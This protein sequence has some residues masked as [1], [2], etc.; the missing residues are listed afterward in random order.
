M[1]RLCGTEQPNV[2]TT[3]APGAPAR[4]AGYEEDPEDASIVRGID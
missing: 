4:P 2:F 1:S 3:R